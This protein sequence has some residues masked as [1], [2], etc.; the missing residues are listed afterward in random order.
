MTRYPGVPGLLLMQAG[1]N[2]AG[3][4]MQS[5]F[6]LVLQQRFQL[7]S[8]ENG[9]VLSWVGLCVATGERVVCVWGG[10]LD[11]GEWRGRVL[12]SDPA[13]HQ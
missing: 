8:R 3:S 10:V 5:T 1:A 6:A 2:L 7:S 9:L 11:K 12:E 4:L 13:S